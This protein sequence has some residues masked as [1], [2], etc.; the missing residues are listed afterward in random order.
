MAVRT[1]GEGDTKKPGGEGDQ[2]IILGS[3]DSGE[4]EKQKCYAQSRAGVWGPTA[5]GRDE[6][7]GLGFQT[8]NERN[9]LFQCGE[10]G[11]TPLNL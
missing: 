7:R 11:E 3:A 9:E 10:V 5:K 6:G 8:E 1:A 2:G 4:G